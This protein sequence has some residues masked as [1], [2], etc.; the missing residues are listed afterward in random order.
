MH[1]STRHTKRTVQIALVRQRGCIE[2]ENKTQEARLR[3][4]DLQ[5]D[6]QVCAHVAH[7]GRAAAAAAA[8]RRGG[9]SRRG[10]ALHAMSQNTNA[11]EPKCYRA[12]P[13]IVAQQY[14]KRTT[15][16]YT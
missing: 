15:V 6:R 8:R 9:A 4:I 14:N 3:Q 2:P 12:Q 10:D 11:P 13:S 7:T 1:A 5:Q 16:M